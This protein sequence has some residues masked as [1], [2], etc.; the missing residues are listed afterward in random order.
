MPYPDGSQLILGIHRLCFL[1]SE[2]SQASILTMGSGDIWRMGCRG[3]AS[4]GIPF[5]YGA[6]T[7]MRFMGRATYQQWDGAASQAAASQAQLAAPLYAELVS[8]AV[9]PH[10]LTS[11]VPR[12]S[13]ERP[14]GPLP[15]P[16]FCAGWA[17]VSPG[18][19]Q[20]RQYGQTKQS[21]PN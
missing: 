10:P 18:V 9:R 21:Q 16:S 20:T 5:S 11:P 4:R 8:A 6:S 1:V 14:L 2:V 13:S 12:R 7:S 3:F 19:R 15:K 17:R